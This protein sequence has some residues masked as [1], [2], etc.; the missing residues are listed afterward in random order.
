MTEDN[1]QSILLE[2][3]TLL[4]ESLQRRNYNAT[5]ILL[6]VS[7]HIMQNNNNISTNSSTADDWSNNND[8]RDNNGVINQIENSEKG[9]CHTIEK[10]SY[11]TVLAVQTHDVRFM[12]LFFSHGFTIALP[13]DINCHCFLC[14]NDQLGQSKKRIETLQA[15]SNP[16]WIGLTSED[17]FFT[18]FKISKLLRKFRSFQDSYENVFKTILK[19]NKGFCCSLLD[20]IENETEVQ[21]LMKWKCKHFKPFSQVKNFDFIRLSIKYK[22]K[23]VRNI[24][25]C[26]L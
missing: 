1:S 24:F 18:S 8:E 19:Q 6:N 4:K 17:P 16:I 21:C 15:L 20:Q 3:E 5:K 12:K 26:F 25:L 23:E 11:Y 13:H 2:W 9:S 7:K 14:A 10:L 22:Q